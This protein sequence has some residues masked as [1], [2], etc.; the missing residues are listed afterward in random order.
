MTVRD[1]KN[2]KFTVSDVNEAQMEYNV[3]SHAT[4]NGLARCTQYLSLSCNGQSSITLVGSAPIFYLNNLDGQ[5]SVLL[6]GMSFGTVNIR[7]NINGQSQLEL[8]DIPGLLSVDG[9]VDGASRLYCR[10]A[11]GVFHGKVDGGSRL[12]IVQHGAGDGVLLFS[13]KVDGKSVIEVHSTG[14]AIHFA[15][16]IDGGS[17]VI[18]RNERSDGASITLTGPELSGEA[19]LILI[20]KVQAHF[21]VVHYGARI[22]DNSWPAWLPWPWPLFS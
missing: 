17:V 6:Q 2:G 16:K 10:I 18:V 4:V 1:L 12:Q 9:M 15:K 21:D 13:E 20:G 14:A 7:G 22:R 8:G 19:E 11:A 3:D 5:S